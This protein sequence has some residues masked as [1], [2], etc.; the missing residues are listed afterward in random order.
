LDNL[1]IFSIANGENGVDGQKYLIVDFG[2]FLTYFVIVIILIIII[3]FLFLIKLKIIYYFQSYQLNTEAGFLIDRR[4]VASITSV[5][6]NKVENKA[7]KT[8][9]G[10]I[11]ATTSKRWKNN[12]LEK[13]LREIVNSFKTYKL[14]SGIFS[15]SS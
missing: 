4:A 14:N 2:F 3:I 12:G 15:A 9:Q 10:L 13:T 6:N 11:G 8:I 1:K 5:N 7:T